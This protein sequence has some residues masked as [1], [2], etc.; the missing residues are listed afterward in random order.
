M[1][2][3][4]QG[5]EDRATDEEEH[6]QTD[7]VNDVAD[8]SEVAPEVGTEPVAT[9]PTVAGVEKRAREALD[10]AREAR[11]YGRGYL[12][13]QLE[14]LAERVDTTEE[15]V[16][17]LE[18]RVD[19]LDTRMEAIAGVADD[20]RSSP[21]KR[22]SDLREALIRAAQARSDDAP[23]IQWWWKEV[24]DNLASL[25]HGRLSKPTYYNT[26]ER[27]AEADGFALTTTTRRIE[28][29]ENDTRVEEVKAIRVVMDD[30]PT[31]GRETVSNQFTTGNTQ[32]TNGEH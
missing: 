9:I 27:A 17:D 3:M 28:R 11:D 15:R 25:G 5:A 6:E 20:Q 16:D 30:L 14:D 13:T 26:M 29:G 32:S 4:T 8:V 2:S 18:A 22:V 10:I 12:A 23:G 21:E 7:D 1:E 19:A 31:S 24:R